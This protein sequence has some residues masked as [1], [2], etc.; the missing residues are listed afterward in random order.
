MKNPFKPKKDKFP[1]PTIPRA[2][3][4]IRQEYGG[5]CARAGEI[6][7]QLSIGQED[8]RRVNAR[9]LEVNT[10]AAERKALDEAVAK[11]AKQTPPVETSQQ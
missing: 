4:A 6:Q 5:L 7:Y 3:D 1:K 11:A 9:L 8:L 10:E 2:L